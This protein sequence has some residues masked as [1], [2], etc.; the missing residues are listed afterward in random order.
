MA[1]N[2]Q[3]YA[4]HV[5]LSYT[6]LDMAEQRCLSRRAGAFQRGRLAG[7]AQRG[8]HHSMCIHLAGAFASGL[9]V[10]LGYVHGQAPETCTDDVRALPLPQSSLT[11]PAARL[12]CYHAW[13]SSRPSAMCSSMSCHAGEWHGS[14]QRGHLV[15][16]T[17]AGARRAGG[18]QWVQAADRQVDP[19]LHR[20]QP[21]PEPAAQVLTKRGVPG[22]SRHLLRACRAD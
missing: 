11:L 7:E 9:S 1:P 21:H 18:P 3:H 12:C 15:E 22:L 10:L 4:C 6:L 13:R 19:V 17:P 8:S 14:D 5:A 20:R 2:A 16:S